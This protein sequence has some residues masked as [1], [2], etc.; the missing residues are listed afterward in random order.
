MM[1]TNP[2]IIWFRQDLRLED[3]AA[4]RAAAAAGPV[5]PVYILDDAAPGDW[6]MGSATRWWLH[7]SLTNLGNDLARKGAQLILRKGDA[8]AIL[9]QLAAEAGAAAIHAI[10]HYEPWARRQEQ[11]LAK[12]GLLRL[13]G[14]V[15]LHNPAQMTTGSG[16]AFKVFTPFWRAMQQHLPPAMPAPAPK[17]LQMAD[18][19]IAR[20]PLASWQLLPRKPDWAAGFD[21]YWTPGAYGALQ[22]LGGFK[23]KAMHYGEVRNDVADNGTSCLAPHLHFG[24]ISAAQVYHGAGAQAEPFLRQ[25]GWRDFSFN[26]LL[27]SP[28]FADVNWKRDF[29]RF[30]WAK[31]AAAYQAWCK[32]RTG[33]PIVDAAMQQLWQTGWMH[34]RARMIVASFLIKDL[35]I[36]WRDGE[37]WFWDTLVDADLANNAAGWQWTAG[38]G[39]DASPYYRI[40]NPITQGQKFDPDG[41]YVRRWLPQLAKLP[42]D[43]I[44]APWEARP[45][46]LLDAGIT[47]GKHYPNP[48][49][50]HAAAREAALLAYKQLKA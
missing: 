6:A 26:L 31:N 10:G 21:Q 39:A 33:Y 5:L 19:A 4:V 15:A 13:H 43:V 38:S 1:L 23:D 46:E 25:L 7:H 47:L 29:D 35:L 9:Q 12:S 36:H 40:F 17:K 45:I 16:T 20:D 32:G 49:V 34:N 27:M 48:M 42:T 30:P 3:Q 14:S 37:R 8:V 44:H 11:Q 2:Q 22:K 28:Y 18:A 41:A 50:N 24:E